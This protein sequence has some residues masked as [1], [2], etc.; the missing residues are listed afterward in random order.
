ML[1]PITG[2]IERRAFGECRVDLLEDRKIRGYALVF[3][4]HSVDLGGFTEVILPEAVDRT[5]KEALDVRALVDHDSSKVLGRTKAG[6]LSLR[7][8]SRGLQV[9]IDPPNTTAARDIL[10]S[11]NR[12]DVSGMSFAFRVLTDDWHMEDETPV[13]EVLDMRISEVS[14]VTFPAYPDTSV[15]LRSLQQFQRQHL[16][17]SIAWWEMV[18]RTR[19]AR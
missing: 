7:K 2:E 17:K 12:G 4:R 1:P 6:T 8:T 5:L 19:M 15:S 13:R 9:E 14:V 10:E 18:H 16:G 11:V 3:N